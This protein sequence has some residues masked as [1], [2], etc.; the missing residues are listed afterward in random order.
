MLLSSEG[1]EVGNE[2]S[3]RNAR[4]ENTQFL[5]NHIPFDGW[6]E[7][8]QILQQYNFGFWFS[9]DLSCPTNCRHLGGRSPYDPLYVMSAAK[10]NG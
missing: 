7:L 10:P 9:L 5:L 6:F 8:Q 1:G 2:R 3:F 4:T